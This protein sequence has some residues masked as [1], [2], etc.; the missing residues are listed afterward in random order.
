MP[1][2]TSLKILS[3][4]RRKKWCIV[5]YFVD[6]LSLIELNKAGGSAEKDRPLFKHTRKRNCEKNPK[7]ELRFPYYSFALSL[8]ISPL[9]RRLIRPPTA[10]ATQKCV[11]VTAIFLSY[12]VYLRFIQ[13][14]NLLR[15]IQLEGMD[16]AGISSD[17]MG[18]WKWTKRP[19]KRKKKTRTEKITHF[20][21]GCFG[22][23][24]TY[25]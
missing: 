22:R 13:P 24:F 9:N 19:K 7:S 15:P 16:R 18:S 11:L 1:H 4:I 17:K 5:L 6:C 14:I 3:T 10:R 2:I 23:E 21:F 8:P 20:I 25:L 12:T